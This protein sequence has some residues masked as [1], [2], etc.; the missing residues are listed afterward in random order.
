MLN[1]QAIATFGAIRQ[2]ER[3]SHIIANNLS[4]VQT[5]GFKKD[6]PLFRSF[7]AEAYQGLMETPED[8]IQTVFDQ[9]PLYRTQHA[10][11]VAIEGEG[12]FKVKVGDEIR[13][14]RGGNFRLDRDGRL[15]DS[16]GRP[17]L[18]QDREITLRGNQIVI[19][20]DGT[21]QVDGNAAGKID[22][23]TFSDLRQLRKE[24][25]NLYVALNPGDERPAERST[26]LQYHLE[27]SNVNPVEEMIN[28][29]DSHRTFESCIK[30]IQAHDALDGRAVNEIGK[31]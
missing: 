31:V 24:G 17:V 8:S 1:T 22:L 10:L 9:G 25:H 20:Q 6:V 28:L 12:F 23:V 29:M 14:T 30:V 7:L 18:G 21:I 5:V 19:G 27:N 13:Y 16:G 4:N 26:I 3:I 11:D 15:L 2:Q